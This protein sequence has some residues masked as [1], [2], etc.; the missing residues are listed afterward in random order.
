[1]DLG[2]V[3]NH[4]K[5]AQ[6]LQQQSELETMILFR[7][8]EAEPMRE[9]PFR[10]QFN[11][12]VFLEM[13]STVSHNMT[14]LQFMPNLKELKLCVPP[15]TGLPRPATDIISN[16]DLNFAERPLLPKLTRLKIHYPISAEDVKKLISWFQDLKDTKLHLDNEGFR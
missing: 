16:T 12:L 1:M 15:E 10:V 14:F 9:F 5:V 11:K 7:G 4:K 2:I 3:V 6:L 8:P 13:T